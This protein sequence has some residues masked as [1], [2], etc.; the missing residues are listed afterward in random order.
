MSWRSQNARRAALER[1]HARGQHGENS[2]ETAQCLAW[3]MRRVL[4]GWAQGQ[5]RDRGSE[6]QGGTRV[7]VRGAH[8]AK[9]PYGSKNRLGVKPEGETR[10]W[11]VLELPIG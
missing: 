10:V 3:G 8:I 6:T 1:C 11:D 2:Y 5:W 7:C 4:R 9:I